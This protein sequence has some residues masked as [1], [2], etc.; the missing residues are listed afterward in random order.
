MVD[1]HDYKESTIT[2][3]LGEAVPENKLAGIQEMWS[4]GR[5]IIG[6]IRNNLLELKTYRDTRDYG[7]DEQNDITKKWASVKKALINGEI[8]ELLKNHLKETKENKVAEEDVEMKEMEKVVETTETMTNSDNHSK[9][10]KENKVAEEETTAPAQSK[11]DLESVDN[12]TRYNE[13]LNKEHKIAEKSRCAVLCRRDGYRFEVQAFRNGA[14]NTIQ[15]YQVYSVEEETERVLIDS[16]GGVKVSREKVLCSKNEDCMSFMRKFD[17]NFTKDDLKIAYE[18]LKKFMETSKWRVDCGEITV[19]DAFELFKE[20]VMQRAD[21]EEKDSKIDKRHYKYNKAKGWFQVS[22]EKFQ[23]ALDDA[24]TG[25]KRRK[26]CQELKMV[27]NSK[28]KVIIL[29][30]RS[31][32]EAEK[33]GEE[34]KKSGKQKK[35]SGY[36]FVDSNKQSWFR[37]A[38]E[39]EE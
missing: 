39:I 13:L 15:S 31:K 12:D 9:E 37:F 18:R 34:E 19:E 14:N 27:E 28:N 22:A 25:F 17:V 26:F 21:V 6:K 4:Q 24:D 38:L 1:T 30:N 2:I 5:R 33:E 23:Q 10:T 36:G 29:G 7:Y 20:L 11:T 3:Q 16:S 32:K 8:P 35:S